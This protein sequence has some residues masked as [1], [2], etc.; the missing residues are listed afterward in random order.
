[1]L[2]LFL[3]II[4]IEIKITHNFIALE[5]TLN[6]TVMHSQVYIERF[7]AEDWEELE[8]GDT[9]QVYEGDRIIT[10]ELGRVYITFDDDLEIL[11]LPHSEII[12]NEL[13]VLNDGRISLKASSIGAS[14]HR[15]PEDSAFD[16]YNFY[17]V[18]SPPSF[19][20]VMANEGGC[21]YV[22]VAE[23][24][25]IISSWI[26]REETVI[27]AGYGVVTCMGRTEPVVELGDYLA[28]TYL[29]G[30]MIDCP[31]YITETNIQIRQSPAIEPITGPIL[32]SQEEVQIFEVTDD[33][34]W[35]RLQYK[36]TLGW[37]ESQY[38]ESACMN[39]LV[40][41]YGTVDRLRQVPQVQPFE[42]ELLSPFYGLS[43]YD[44]WFYDQEE[45]ASTE[46]GE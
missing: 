15:Y 43:R 37:V 25:G 33:G 20:S 1:M 12:L 29:V 10:G 2:W 11:L 26:Y 35:Y 38:I 23:G 44:P 40:T 24:T 22:T 14:I 5:D 19:F 41:S 31:G 9:L 6:L 13:K 34:E 27:D 30:Q 42:L 8:E 28:Y 39:L 18:V 4:L 45:N 3:I 16:Q 46:G 17:P 36:S 7:N 32:S 21:G